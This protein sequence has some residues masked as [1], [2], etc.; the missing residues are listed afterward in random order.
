MPGCADHGFDS[1]ILSNYDPKWF[2]STMP[3]L[4]GLPKGCGLHIFGLPF[5]INFHDLINLSTLLTHFLLK[6][7]PSK[8]DNF[9]QHC[10]H[11]SLTSTHIPIEDS[12]GHSD[13]Q[14]PK[15]ATH[16]SQSNVQI[17]ICLLKDTCC[18]MLS[19]LFLPGP[20]HR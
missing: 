20:Y 9:V 7:V 2:V 8:G 13:T 11:P 12:R 4:V 1:H 10:H 17:E 19:L 15:H 14:Y 5:H 6:K 18:F 3:L 16:M